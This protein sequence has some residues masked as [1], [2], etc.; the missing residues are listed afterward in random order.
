MRAF[1]FYHNVLILS[2][3][4]P[5]LGCGQPSGGFL[6]PK[7]GTEMDKYLELVDSFVFDEVD[8]F[9]VKSQKDI[10]GI[11]YRLNTVLDDADLIQTRLKMI[12]N[13]LPE[14]DK[15]TGKTIEQIDIQCGRVRESMHSVF[16]GIAFAHD[17]LQNLVELAPEP[18][19]LKKMAKQVLNDK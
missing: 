6:L 8:N 4:T 16:K 3:V 10:D 18:Q 9:L 5:L 11:R 19:R 1:S 12:K 14:R 17:S 7:K 15:D 2:T 13:L